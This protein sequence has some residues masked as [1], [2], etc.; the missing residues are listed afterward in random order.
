MLVQMGVARAIRAGAG[1]S[2][3]QM[4]GY[5]PGASGA[6]AG[7][8]LI[9]RPAQ[10]WVQVWLNQDGLAMIASLHGRYDEALPLY[11]R[12]LQ[13][14]ASAFPR[15]GSPVSHPSVRRCVVQV[16]WTS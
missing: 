12:A 6:A 10:C 9:N 2:T 5:D 3:G 14:P 8:L 1:T 15:R 11:A 7:V 13:A 4:A 16:V